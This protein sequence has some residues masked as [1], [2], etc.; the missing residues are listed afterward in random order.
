MFT[1]RAENRLSLRADTASLRLC[2][3]AI[4]NNMLNKEEAT[5]KTFLHAYNKLYAFIKVPK[6]HTTIKNTFI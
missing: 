4:K 2:D 1:S 6:L 3:I 5:Y